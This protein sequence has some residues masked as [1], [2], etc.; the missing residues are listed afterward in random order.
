M[1]TVPGVLLIGGT[2]TQGSFPS[3]PTPMVAGVDNLDASLLENLRDRK[4]HRIT[5]DN[6]ATGN[7]TADSISCWPWYDGNASSDLLAVVASTTTSAQFTLGGVS[8]GW[9]VN[10]HQGRIYSETNLP[11]SVGFRQRLVITANT[12]DT[13]TF[14]AAL[15]PA[16]TSIGFVGDGRFTDYH[17]AAG[18]LWSNEVGVS[19]STRGG[20]SWQGGG[21]GVGC[22]IS[23]VRELFERVYNEAPYFHLVKY[24]SANPITTYWGDPPNGTA[25]VAFAAEKT[26]V[27]A[28]ASARGNTISWQH[29]I[30]DFTNEDVALFIGTP[31]QILNYEARLRQMIGWLRQADNLGNTDLSIILVNHREDM[32]AVTGAGA[33][34]FMNNVHR[35]IASDTVGVRIVSCEGYRP[36]NTRQAH[37]A[38]VKCYAQFEY[39]R[40]GDDIANAILMAN[41]GVL[42]TPTNGFPVYIMI[43]DSIYTGPATSAWVTA[44]ASPRISGPNAPANLIRPANQKVW[45][46][47]GAALAIYTPGTNSNTQ[48]SVAF[49]D[50]SGPDLSIMARLGDLHPDGFA[51]IKRASNGSSLATALQAYS[52]GDYGR[53]SKAVSNEHYTAL[54]A[55]VAECDRYINLITGKQVDRRGIFVC[56]GQND[57][58]A[59]GSTGGTAFAAALPTFCDDLRADY[60]TR[61]SGPR[62]PIMWRRPQSDVAG[63][64]AVEIAEIRAALAA[65]EVVDTQFVAYDVDDLERD[66]TDDLHETPDSAVTD[67]DRAVDALELIAI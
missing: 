53:W 54:L 8:P 43:G 60:T 19:P 28:A 4:A 46:A 45:D 33:V 14:S 47:V 65:Q 11:L 21:F 6:E 49:G 44:S 51:M 48:G 29:A 10:E 59:A 32:W 9:T 1:A 36:A 5:P 55:Q 31:A 15:A 34:P 42:T 13:I 2:S 26:R 41:Q 27:D 61:T 62:L 63:V 67:G 64:S 25:R 56:L 18:F 30:I 37:D 24:A 3:E 38:E 39:I 40:M 35:T 20:S 22:D 17:P 52:S 23:L 50:F 16:L 7:P 57:Q 12:A 66:V 58:A